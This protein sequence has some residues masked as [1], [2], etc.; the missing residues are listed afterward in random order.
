MEARGSTGGLILVNFPA[1]RI[2]CYV[3]GGLLTAAFLIY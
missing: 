1:T 3:H 2:L